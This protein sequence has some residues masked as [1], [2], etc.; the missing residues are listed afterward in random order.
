MSVFHHFQTSWAAEKKAVAFFFCSWKKRRPLRPRCCVDVKLFLKRC[1]FTWNVVLQTGPE[2]EMFVNEEYNEAEMSTHAFTQWWNSNE[3][4]QWACLFCLS[5]RLSYA[6][7]WSSSAADS[8][9][10]N[11]VDLFLMDAA[12]LWSDWS[13]SVELLQD[14]DLD[15][16][17]FNTVRSAHCSRWNLQSL[18]GQTVAAGFAWKGWGEKHWGERDFLIKFS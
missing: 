5:R 15:N 12:A 8:P 18:C 4:Q 9:Q 7:F 2:N 14:L 16:V 1:V 17:K 11:F 3:E 10:L 6:L 13:V